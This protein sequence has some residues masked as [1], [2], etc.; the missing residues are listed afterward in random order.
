MDTGTSNDV[1]TYHHLSLQEY[2]VESEVSREY[3]FSD[4]LRHHWIVREEMTMCETRV[5][6]TFPWNS[7][8]HHCH[9]HRTDLDVLLFRLRIHESIGGGESKDFTLVNKM[10][11]SL[12]RM[13]KSS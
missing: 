11:H 8:H 1:T 3:Q 5:T 9:H 6:A 13:S 7:Y 2:L 4:K 12:V 10:Q